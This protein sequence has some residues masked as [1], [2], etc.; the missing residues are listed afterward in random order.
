QTMLN[1]LVGSGLSGRTVQYVRAVLR[2]AL[3]QAMRWQFVP[4]N[5][6][7]LVDPPKAARPEFPIL[8]PK[9]LD[10]FIAAV[11]DHRLRALYLTS[12]ALGLRQGESFGLRWPDLDFERST[13]SVRYA[14]SQGEFVEPKTRKSRRALVMPAFVRDAL[15]RHRDEQEQERR[16]A[17]SRWQALDLVF[18]ST[19]GTPLNSSNVLHEFQAILKDAGLPKLRFHDLRHQCATLLLQKGVHPKVVSDILGHSQISLTLDT[20][21]H[22]LLTLKAE[23]AETMEQ[24]LGPLATALATTPKS[25][26]PN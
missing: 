19:I 9:Q 13:L 25:D 8:T 7:T 18:C 21:S 11:A 15:L 2:R 23:A 17:G 10:T 1:D 26:R 5:A 22:V 16:L 3:N 14:L 20:Y 12:T 24:A 6:A 4:H